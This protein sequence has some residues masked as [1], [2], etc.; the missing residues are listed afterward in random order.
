MTT[1]GLLRW[2]GSLWVRLAHSIRA[3]EERE[4][5]S[6]PFHGACFTLMETFT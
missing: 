5:F 3:R 1:L 4:G 6:R 2:R